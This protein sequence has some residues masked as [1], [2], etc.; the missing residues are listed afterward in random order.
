MSHPSVRDGEIEKRP[1]TTIS[2]RNI[3]PPGTLFCPECFLRQLLTTTYSNLSQRFKFAT[4][5]QLITRLL[6]FLIGT[7]VALI[8]VA[9]VVELVDHL[10]I[11]N[12]KKNPANPVSFLA[13][14]KILNT[15][16]KHISQRWQQHEYRM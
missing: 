6:F 8:P 10:S 2:S 7:V 5:E 4:R 9:I 14:L 16:Q 13:A 11:L 12:G 15:N 1:E 3:I